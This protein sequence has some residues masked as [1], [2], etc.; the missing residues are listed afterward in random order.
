M[1]VIRTTDL[2]HGATDPGWTG[3]FLVV[4][5]VSYAW[6]DVAAGAA[7]I[8]PHHHHDRHEVWEVRSGSVRIRIGDRAMVVG[9][10]QVAVI[11]PNVEH[12][13][14]A[15]ETARLLVAT[16]PVADTGSTSVRRPS[17]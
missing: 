5:G 15:T 17:H 2:L 13:I 16:H 6:W 12:G 11:E 1:T 3:R 14:E 8:Q 7:S 10:G 9:P 4:G